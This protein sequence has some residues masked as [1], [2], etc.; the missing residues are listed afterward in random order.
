M[1]LYAFGRSW[2]GVAVGD[3]VAIIDKGFTEEGIRLTGRVS[4]IERDLLGGDATVTF[5][6]LINSMADM[7]QSVSPDPKEQQPRGGDL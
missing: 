3:R 2:E 5:G 7:W 6:N 1:T 4:Q